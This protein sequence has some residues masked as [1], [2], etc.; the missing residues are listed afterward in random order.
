M[1]ALGY[2][3]F[4]TSATFGVPGTLKAKAGVAANANPDVFCY[5]KSQKVFGFHSVY[6]PGWINRSG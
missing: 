2:S 1:P 6:K 5:L 3:R 4:P